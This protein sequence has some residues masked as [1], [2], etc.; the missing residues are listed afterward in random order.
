MTTPT[1]CVLLWDPECPNVDLARARLRQAFATLG[2]ERPSSAGKLPWEERRCDDP[3]LPPELRGYGSPTILVGG[4]D[5]AGGGPTCGEGCRVYGGGEGGEA[6]SGAPSVEALVAALAGRGA[7]AAGRELGE[8]S[9]GA[10]GE[11]R[12]RDPSRGGGVLVLVRHGETVGNSSIRLYGA[13]D[14]DLSPLGE[15]QLSRAGEALADE[16]FDRFITSPM[17]RARRSASIVAEALRAPAPA[18]RVVEALRER[19]FGD[20]EGWTIDEVAERD[21]AGYERWQTQGLDFSFPGGD[22]RRDLSSRVV[23]ALREDVDGGPLFP[24]SER[25]LAVLHKGII[26]VILGELLG[27]D[28]GEA[29]ALTVTLGSIHRLRWGEDRWHL[30]AGNLTEHLGEHFLES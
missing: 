9:P 6:Y 10:R 2:R 18:L 19:N 25:T 28:H 17:L 7:P 22:S 3:T 21:P 14:I 16:R 26:K 29:Q 24:P 8:S 4:R 30:E 13:T 20:W 11:S 12:E 27:L 15:A 5:V 23:A 1:S